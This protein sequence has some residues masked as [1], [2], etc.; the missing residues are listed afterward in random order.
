MANCHGLFQEY[1]KTIKLSASKKELLR[2]GRNSLRKI[3][4]N[5]FKENLKIKEPKFWSQGSYALKTIVNPI[6]GDYDID[7]GVYLQSIDNN[8]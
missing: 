7:D 6:N 2:K 3:I 5:F 1:H 4:K 8:N